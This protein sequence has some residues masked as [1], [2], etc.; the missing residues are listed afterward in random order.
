M[1]KAANRR[2]VRFKC[3]LNRHVPFKRRKLKRSISSCTLENIIFIDMQN[4][5]LQK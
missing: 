3:R 1:K 4:G 5:I 2:E